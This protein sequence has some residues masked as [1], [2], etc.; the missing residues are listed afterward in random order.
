MQRMKII[1]WA[2]HESVNFWIKNI[3]ILSTA[4]RNQLKYHYMAFH[5]IVHVLQM[6]I[7]SGTSMNNVYCD[8][9]AVPIYYGHIQNT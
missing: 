2:R 6:E 9:I 7:E 1:V 5:A 8:D 3:K 4:F